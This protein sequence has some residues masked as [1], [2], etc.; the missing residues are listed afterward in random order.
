MVGGICGE[1]CKAFSGGAGEGKPC[2]G[3]DHRPRAVH[4]G[5]VAA[6]A[7]KPMV[8]LRVRGTVN[9]FAFRTSLFP[10]RAA[11]SICWNRAMQAGAGVGL[12]DARVPPAAGP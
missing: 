12:G 5:G 4:S 9:G 2:A 8:R 7:G 11:L 10:M 1:P 6:A 3:L